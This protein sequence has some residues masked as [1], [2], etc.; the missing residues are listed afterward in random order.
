MADSPW[1]VEVTMENFQEVVV[2]G[3]RQRPVVI[4]F[5]AE[6]CGPC[7]RLA[8]LLEQL[9]VQRNGGFL[10]AKVN[11]DEAPDL[12]QAFRVDGIPAVFAV[13]DGQVVNHFTGLLPEDALNEF[14]DS[15]GPA[16]PAE[17]AEP[18]P[19][20]RAIEL[21]GRDPSAAAEAYRAMLAAAPDDPAA[22]VGLAR[23]LL[24]TPGRESEATPLLAG[25]E[26]G[27][28]ATEA[29]R[30]DTVIQLRAVPHTDSDLSAARGAVGAE[31]KLT[32][33][34]V[35]AARGEYPLALDA[36]LEAAEDDKQLGRT[37]VRE[38]MLKVFEVIG[39]RSEQADDYRRRLQSLLY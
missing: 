2:N 28:F 37:T 12:A 7:R 38:L 31:G 32:L 19:L 24:A 9:A 36:L 26:F 16:A 8:P 25:D 30:L 5:W 6:W 35:L 34:K 1:I 10:L 23:V 14:I 39:P 29:K 18:T 11:T 21:E 15:L 33:A 3:S 27:D 4:D 13:R 22:R 20:D 17:P